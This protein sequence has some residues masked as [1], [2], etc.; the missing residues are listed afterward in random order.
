[1]CPTLRATSNSSIT[2]RYEKIQRQIEYILSERTN[3]ARLCF[4]LLPS[5]S[6]SSAYTR[7][8]RSNFDPY[9]RLRPHLSSPSY[10]RAKFGAEST[11]P[12]VGKSVLP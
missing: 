11:T 6:L 4:K 12:W 8:L 2:S 5:G 1:M 10:G 7:V 9:L 3:L